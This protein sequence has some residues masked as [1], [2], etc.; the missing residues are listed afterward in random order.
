MSLHPTR[1]VTRSANG[2]LAIST[3]E[4]AENAEH[5][6]KTVSATTSAVSVGSAV[7]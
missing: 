6:Q 1:D 3:A 4:G 2:H 5:G 7:Q